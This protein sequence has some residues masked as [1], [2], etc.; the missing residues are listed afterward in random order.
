MVY[1]NIIQH[2]KAT[3]SL[4]FGHDFDLYS[5]LHVWAKMETNNRVSRP[6]IWNP[7]EDLFYI[8]YLLMT[9]DLLFDL[10]I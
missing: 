5:G 1:T 3:D 2:C 7:L 10:Q 4:F 6:Y 9:F 8:A